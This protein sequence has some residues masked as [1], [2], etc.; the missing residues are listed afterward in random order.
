MGLT[1]ISWFEKHPT[2]DNYSICAVNNYTMVPLTTYTYN[3]SQYTP[4]GRFIIIQQGVLNSTTPGI[5]MLCE[6][7]VYVLVVPWRHFH[8]V[9]VPNLCMIENGFKNCLNCW[10]INT[11]QWNDAVIENTVVILMH[12]TLLTDKLF[13]TNEN[14]LFGF[15]LLQFLNKKGFIR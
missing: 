5:F 7:Q 1:N 4:P 10:S 15:A 13:I 12:F 6:V 11:F 3:C 14:I 8:V 9:L 2:R